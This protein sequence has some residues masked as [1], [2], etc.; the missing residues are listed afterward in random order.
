MTRLDGTSQSFV[1]AFGRIA[2]RRN[3]SGP[4][5]LATLRASA[6]ARFLDLGLPSMKHE[7][8]RYTNLRRMAEIEF[9]PAD[10][11][12]ISTFDRARLDVGVSP[13]GN[14]H[15]LV[16]V[17]GRFAAD[18]SNRNEWP[19]G[20]SMQPLATAETGG[21]DAAAGLLGH[22]AP[23]EQRPFAALNSAL[24]DDGAFIRLDPGTRLDAPLCLLF[25]SDASERAVAVHPRLLLWAGANSR[26]V[27]IEI[28]VGGDGTYLSNAV[29]EIVLD[30]GA[31]L[32]LYKLQQ[33]GPAAYHI[34][35][36][37]VRQ[38]RDSHF[39]YTALMLGGRLSRNA[40]DVRLVGPGASCRLDGLSLGREEQHVDCPALVDHA[41]PHCTS[42]QLYKTVLDDRAT[43]VFNGKVV[44]RPGA[45]KTDAVQRNRNL[46]LAK[47]AVAFTRP[48]LEI[49][50]DDVK[51]SHGA[52]V[53]QIDAQALFYLRSRG[54]DLESARAMLVHSFALEV[55]DRVEHAEI[56]NSMRGVVRTWMGTDAE[57]EV[58]S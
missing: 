33:E 6:L 35:E 56:R 43:A 34:A 1:E 42:D 37:S 16:F 22:V 40:V 20:L 5:W 15:R 29:T 45:T 58:A 47:S 31:R 49:Y 53:G 41:A 7:D 8:W 50:A 52:T 10:A 30:D 23:F 9:Q 11:S 14:T 57:I 46:L 4:G 25:V 51:C 36:T 2:A 54:I 55:L 28:H 18:A 24:F 19:A 12:A 38:A 17:N 27:V 3:G 44:V 13:A 26:A 48:Q 39:A 21:C 32:D